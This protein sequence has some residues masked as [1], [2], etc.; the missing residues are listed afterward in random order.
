MST[1]YY[2]QT[3]NLSDSPV[4]LSIRAIRSVLMY[5][6][7]WSDKSLSK[8]QRMQSIEAGQQLCGAMVDN[9]LPT[10]PEKEQLLIL[11]ILTATSVDLFECSINENK[12]LFENEHALIQLIDIMQKP[13]KMGNNRELFTASYK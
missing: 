8:L 7:D 12:S 1:Q 11:K 10:L 2:K 6:Q 3:Q 9:I 5:C 13:T 4:Q